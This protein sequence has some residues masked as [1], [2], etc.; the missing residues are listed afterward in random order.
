[1]QFLIAG[2]ESVTLTVTKQYPHEFF[3]WKFMFSNSYSVMLKKPVLYQEQN[4]YLAAK[5]S[6]SFNIVL[7]SG[8]CKSCSSILLLLL[9]FQ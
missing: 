7:A 6:V 4:C 1:M 8:P 2:S 5:I 3:N 9:R